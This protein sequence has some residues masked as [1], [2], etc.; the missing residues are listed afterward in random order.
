MGNIPI[1]QYSRTLIISSKYDFTL[2]IASASE[3][4]YTRFTVHCLS[5]NE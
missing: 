5:K 1:F 3:L 4:A 2:F